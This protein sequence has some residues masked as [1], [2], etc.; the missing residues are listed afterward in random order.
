M[1]E[2]INIM[3]T[4]ANPSLS[5]KLFLLAFLPFFIVNNVT[6][7][8]CVGKFLLPLALSSRF[9]ILEKSN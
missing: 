2:Y 3:M 1:Y 4:Q 7:N 6:K 5:D 8:K 9:P